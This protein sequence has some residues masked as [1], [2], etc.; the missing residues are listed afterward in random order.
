M[1]GR[2]EMGDWPAKEGADLEGG[3]GKSGA[4][5]PNRA[6]DAAIVGGR[7]KRGDAGVKLAHSSDAEAQLGL[8]DAARRRRDGDGQTS[9][10]I[11][12]CTAATHTPP[13]G[14]RH[15]Y[16][17][18]PSLLPKC[19]RESLANNTSTRHLDVP[20]ASLPC[21]RAGPWLRRQKAKDEV[22]LYMSIGSNP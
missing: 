8:I 11:R 17:R 21:R 13:Y 10:L 22:N 18:P 1:D 14:P 4:G 19:G 7:A 16:G 6:M 2:W 3:A 15:G 5:I 12:S 20:D 9:R